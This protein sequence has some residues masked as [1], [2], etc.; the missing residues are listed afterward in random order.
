MKENKLVDLSKQFAID[1]I[2]LCS[3]VK[4]SKKEISC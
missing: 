4:E 1:I 3:D 2:T